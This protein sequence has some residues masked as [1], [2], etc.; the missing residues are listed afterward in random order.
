LEIN[1]PAVVPILRVRGLTKSFPLGSF[2]RRST[3][4]VNNVDLDVN[5]EEI[6][7]IV[8]E[9]GAGK[10]TLMRCSLRLLEPSSGSVQFKGEELTLLSPASLRAKRKE[11]QMI[12]QDPYASLNPYMTVEQILMEPLHVHKMGDR[13]YKLRQV[14]EMLEVVS[15]SQSIL[16]RKSSELS[17]GQQQRV[18]IARGLILNPRLLVADEPVSALDAS[19]Q[20]QILNLMAELKKRY[21][22]TMILISHSLSAIHYLCTHIS[23]LYRGRLIEEAPADAFFNNPR[24]PYSKALLEAT[25]VL[26]P[27]KLRQAQSATIASKAPQDAE[28]GCAYYPFCSHRLLICEHQAPPLSKVKKCE[29]VACFLHSRE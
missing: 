17:G 7:G 16:N 26:D 23:V 29:S 10:S 6:R 25:P 8:G 12:F 28:S 5:A 15:L 13:D 18:G 3:C 1:N 27:T 20:A 21:S 14:R 24:H 19:V 2:H 9:S 11:F 4:V 22:L